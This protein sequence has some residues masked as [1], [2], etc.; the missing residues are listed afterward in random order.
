MSIQN[1]FNEMRTMLLHFI[2]TNPMPFDACLSQIESQLCN[3]L[4]RVTH[5]IQAAILQRFVVDYLNPAEMATLFKKLEERAD[6]A[7]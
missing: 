3:C 7:R 6:E 5:E 4:R 2:M 1:S